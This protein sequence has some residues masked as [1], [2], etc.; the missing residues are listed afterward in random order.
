MLRVIAG[1][2]KGRRLICPAGKVTRPPTDLLKGAVFNILAD[3]VADARVLDLFA[4]SGAFGIEALSRGAAFCL[5][6]ERHDAALAALRRNL[7][8]V[9][10]SQRGRI[11]RAEA[12]RL[13]PA[14]RPEGPFQIVFIDPPFARARAS[15]GATW[16]GRLLTAALRARTGAGAV[17]LRL[18]R[19]R[20][21]AAETLPFPD[22]RRTYGD[23][24]VCFFYAE[25]GAA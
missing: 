13:D 9:G 4:G 8:H 19:G 17:V 3:R 15:D 11:L 7:A 14:S 5:F 12:E 22:D 23:S 24:E 21:R 10:F 18:P 1:S 20:P 16:T 6:V 2:A 25:G